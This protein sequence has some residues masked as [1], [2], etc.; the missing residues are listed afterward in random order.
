MLLSFIEPPHAD[1]HVRWCEE[2]TRQRESFLPDFVDLTSPNAGLN[3]ATFIEPLFAE[4]D[5][6]TVVHVE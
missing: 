6:T 3:L 2:G 1:P 4:V 5:P